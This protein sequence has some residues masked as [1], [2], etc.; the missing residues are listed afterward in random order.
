[1]PSG[2]DVDLITEEEERAQA[3]VFRSDAVGLRRNALGSILPDHSAGADD[4]G[5]P[6]PAI[7]AYPAAIPRDIERVVAER[8]YKPVAAPIK[9]V[10]HQFAEHV[11]EVVTRDELI[12]DARPDPGAAL[13]AEVGGGTMPPPSGRRRCSDDDAMSDPC[14]LAA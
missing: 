8:H 12:H 2:A 10:L 11:T 9:L 1:M 6:F 13:V 14:A 4:D 7:G 3:K 5:Q